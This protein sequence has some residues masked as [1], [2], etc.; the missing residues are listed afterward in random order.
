MRSVAGPE[1]RG[2]AP[3]PHRAIPLW[4]VRMIFAGVVVATLGASAPSR[5]GVWIGVGTVVGA[6]LLIGMG[7][8]GRKV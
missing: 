3:A 7:L 8:R 6:G 1:M 4:T 5:V 2:P